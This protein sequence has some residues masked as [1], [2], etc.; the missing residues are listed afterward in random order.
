MDATLSDPL[1][2]RRLDGRY[3]V[4]GRL[5]RGGMGVVYRAE[6]ERLER[7]VALKVLRA[8]L[9][10][11][12]TARAR[13]VREAKSAARLA[14][15][16]VVAV[17]DQG[18]DHTGGVETAYLVMELVDGR[19]LRDVVLDEGALTPGEALS[20]TEDVLQALAEAHRKGVLHRDVKTANVLVAHD[21][22]V[23]V[24][25]FG[26][27]RAASASGQS[28]TVGMGD[29]MGTAEYL[30]PEQLENGEPDARSD[31]YGVGVML[32]EMLT[33]APPFTGESPFSIAYK[34][35]HEP[36]PAPSTKVPG[37]PR[38]LDAL[39]LDALAKDPDERP[40]DAG[41]MLEQL[42]AVR[43]S[44]SP[45]Q[46]QVRAPRP[47]APAVPG[48]TTR[49]AAVEAS[50]APQAPQAVRSTTPREGGRRSRRGLLV[51]LVLIVLALAA[52][53][54]WFFLA[55]PGAYT[56]T[57]AVAGRSPQEASALLQSAGLAVDEQ[58]GF[59]D[60]VEKG[61]VASSDPGD[62]DRVR[63]GGTVTIVVS[64]GVQTFAVPD[65]TGKAQTDAED[66]LRTTG[67]AVG[68][69]SEEFSEDVGQGQVV[70]TDPAAGQVLAHDTPVNL[71]VSKGR[72]P[73]DVPTVTNQ[74]QDDAQKAITDRGLAVGRVTQQI[75]E[76]VAKGLVISQTPDGGTLFR[77]DAV[78][79]VVSSGPPLVTIP[80]VQGK[81]VDAVR[82]QLQGLGF[83]VKVD[84]ILGGVFG[85]VRSIDPG[86]GQQI[87][88][89]STVTL[90]VV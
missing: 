45:E 23:K 86:E 64:Q 5:G 18:V 19:T 65:L 31:V 27:A 42:R 49:I 90:T 78:S 25:D 88:K 22:R 28:T 36:V 66:Q 9:A 83:T 11:D 50:E 12:P 67:L 14:H 24:A 8:D 79:L 70:R 29:L 16:G 30:A 51:G 44:L 38:A 47:A 32:Y 54:S 53:V 13:F 60:T 87:P 59:S 10:H 63:K 52:G 2:G 89:G 3:R 1:V 74:S 72:Q 55:G 57:P 61:V 76:T 58:Q 69:V 20:V 4:L 82:A 41:E 21:G 84:N 39:V 17:L 85:T 46:L 7:T 68:Q 56:T 71:V 48:S 15:P 34:H 75:S 35:V 26:L 40:G 43:S 62:G 80:K 37:L 77:G 6:D 73:I 81:N 33:G